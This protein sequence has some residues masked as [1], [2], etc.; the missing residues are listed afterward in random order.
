MEPD[1]ARQ[2][3]QRLVQRFLLDRTNLAMI[4]MALLILVLGSYAAFGG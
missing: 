1:A 4:V 3:V 2:F